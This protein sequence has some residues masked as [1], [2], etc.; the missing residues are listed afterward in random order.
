MDSLPGA[1]IKVFLVGLLL[2]IFVW[3]PTATAQAET[4]CDPPVEKTILNAELKDA[5]PAGVEEQQATVGLEQA[6]RIAKEAF[7]VPEGL[8]EFSTGFDQ[9][10]SGAFWNLRWY[11]SEEPGGEMYVRVNSMTGD[12]WSMGLWVP[13][14]EYQGLP[15]YSR[16]QLAGTATALAQKLQPERFKSTRLQP[17]R[18]DGYQPLPLVK[19]GQ[20]E[21]GY[22][23]SRVVNGFPFM[24]NGIHIVLSGDTGQVIRFDLTWDNTKEFPSTAGMISAQQAEQIFRNEVGPEL[25]Y[26]RERVPG[27]SKVPLKLVYQLPGQQNQAVIDAL[28]GKVIS[29]GNEFFGYDR[30]GAGGAMKEMSRN[31]AM[32][33]SPMESIAVEEAKGL[34]SKDEALELAVK[35]VPI[36]PEYVLSNSRLEQDY[37][38][39][40]VKTWY[41]AWGA[42]SGAERK[43]MDVAV[44][45]ADGG[46]VSFNTNYYFYESTKPSAV[47]FQEQDALK[48][49]EEYIKRIQPS[50]WDEVVY[51][52]CR[53][54]YY[55]ITDGESAPQPISYN[56]SWV[57]LAN[58]VQFPNN[59]FNVVVNS[60]TGE[61]TSYNMTWWDVKFPGQEGVMS[62]QEAAD[63]Y[64][65]ASPLD[66]AYQRHWI[67]QPYSK[68][69][70]IKPYLVYYT[71]GQNFTMLD[72]FTG[73]LLDFSGNPVVPSPREQKFTDLDSHPAREAV[74]LLARSG[75]VT[76]TDGMFRPDDAVSQAELI[77]MLVKSSAWMPA[78]VYRQSD[79]GEEPWYQ[80][81]YKM[82]VRLGIIQAGE[83]PDPDQPVNREVLAR[84]TI[85]TM[86]LYRVAVLGDIY[87]L[88]FPDAG[89]ITEHLRG[90]VALAAGLGLIEPVNGQ[91]K[92]KTVVTRGEAAQSLVRM[93]QSN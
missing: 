3:L 87:K 1:G 52:N 47:K 4:D 82:A 29:G 73:Q 64:L 36:P 31:E 27:G 19:R 38:F 83:N 11:C 74:E 93:L 75:I 77:T 81:Y 84:L 72:A 5:T 12:I 30:A 9:S 37:L 33:L 66:A 16:D 63:K 43:M 25:Y 35:T 88:D 79:T 14:E 90:H 8:D 49:A 78:P 57:R 51:V 17:A 76:T 10:E 18:D 56:F 24:E 50:R 32:S 7:P 23:Y 6:I 45:A 60:T 21:Y 22:E 67:G 71:T 86:N 89:D 39:N 58:G 55:H 54:D 40:D 34:L 26:F 59:G 62:R 42:G 68:G 92:P 61:V 44:N 85:H 65:Q 20:M 91:L 48:I 69:E 15:Q 46:L 41:F 13:S 2:S 70:E 28:S 53:P 80:Q